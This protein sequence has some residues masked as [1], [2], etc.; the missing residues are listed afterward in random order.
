MSSPTPDPRAARVAPARDLQFAVSSIPA[1]FADSGFAIVP[2]VM[3]AIEVDALMRHVERLDPAGAG[4]RDVLDHAWAQR[5][6][7]ELRRRLVDRAALAATDI[8][9][10]CTYF[11]KSAERNWLVPYHQDLAIPV[12]E[13]VADPSLT[14][15]SRK[16][17]ALFVHAPAAVLE[18][19]TAVR[20]HLD[21]CPAE[22]G[23][24]RVIPGTHRAGRLD[25]EAIRAAR[26]AGREVPCAIG[27][28][29]VLAMRPLLLHASSKMTGPG[30]R[31]VLH[32]LFGPLELPVPLRW[33]VHLTEAAK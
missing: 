10:Q 8:P 26:A 11:E 28:G 33:P 4:M 14:G 15:W 20:L 13:R 30:S 7:G 32:F 25:D 17:G 21:A 23:A 24:L 2:D 19:L 3:T 27:R 9:V 1:G 18:T 5:L 16:A 12:A 31:R 6:A 29:G 22:A